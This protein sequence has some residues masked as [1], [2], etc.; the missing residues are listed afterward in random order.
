MPSAQQTELFDLSPTATS[1][2]I[3][4]PSPLQSPAAGDNHGPIVLQTSAFGVQI[5][6]GAFARIEEDERDC[7][8]QSL[9]HLGRYVIRKS[10]DRGRKWLKRTLTVDRITESA[11]GSKT[12][13]LPKAKLR[14]VLSILTRAGFEPEVPPTESCFTWL[15]KAEA[16]R[17]A[18]R[19]PFGDGTSL[20]ELAVEKLAEA[21]MKN[22]SGVIEYPMA[23]GKSLMIAALIRLFPNA[24]PILVTGSGTQDTSRLAVRIATLTNERV[25]LLG[26]AG[27]IRRSE[28]K[29]LI[30]ANWRKA[31][32]IVG[33]HELLQNVP[34][35]E[36]IRTE[37]E[38]ADTDTDL[39]PTFEATQSD[40][41]QPEL[42]ELLR[43]EIVAHIADEV[44]DMPTVRNLSHV[45]AM[46]PRIF[47]GFSGTW[48]DRSDHC[49][50]VLGDLLHVGGAESILARA[51]HRDGVAT[52]RVTTVELHSYVFRQEDYPQQTIDGRRRRDPDIV[53]EFI[54][55]HDGRNRFA[56]ELLNHLMVLNQAEGRGTILAYTK[57]IEHSHLIVRH[58]AAVRGFKLTAEALEANGILV[59][60]AQLKDQ[61]RIENVL[62]LTQGRYRLAI[63]T[64]TLAIGFDAPVVCDSVDLTGRKEVRKS[65]Q[66][67]G[68]PLRRH[69]NKFIARVHLVHDTHHPAFANNSRAKISALERKFETAAVLHPAT[70]LDWKRPLFE[71]VTDALIDEELN[72][73]R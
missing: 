35:L 7:L 8:I 54:I 53:Q 63:T 5:P 45:L 12:L 13:H 40:V 19:Q 58:I 3:D 36:C 15:G 33:T 68:R 4:L 73:A 56:A 2:A 6:L 39:L 55:Q 38:S 72:L 21:I 11:D 41:S 44:D 28:H 71:R 67:A 52:G 26:C 34:P 50:R 14:E 64:D 17:E 66:R 20:D 9:R 57:T 1:A 48:L 43:S 70:A 27:G 62:E 25:A 59:H 23:G 69:E 22:S 42:G 37:S 30:T 18:L 61:V 10:V 49:D 60:N 24:R 46:E 51:T 16:L 31:R 65:I 29:E 32:I 47:L